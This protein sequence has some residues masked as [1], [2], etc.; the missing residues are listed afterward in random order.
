V[1]VGIRIQSGL[2]WTFG[3]GLLYIIKSVFFNTSRFWGCI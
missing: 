1:D 3:F 2:G